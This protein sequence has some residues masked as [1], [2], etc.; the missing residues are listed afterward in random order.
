MK[1]K[2]DEREDI[3]ADYKW[4]GLSKGCFSLDNLD[5]RCSGD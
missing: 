4:R 3:Y 2:M 5:V 1:L